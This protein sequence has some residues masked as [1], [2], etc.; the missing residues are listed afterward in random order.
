[1]RNGIAALMVAGSIFAASTT[2]GCDKGP[3]DKVVN[4]NEKTTS[5]PDGTTSTQEQKTV[6]HSDGS[7]TTEKHTD[8]QKT[9]P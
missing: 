8:S 4:Q 9:S 5:N 7:V 1:M 2:I 3:G 6:Q